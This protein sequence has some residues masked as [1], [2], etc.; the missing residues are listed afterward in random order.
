MYYLQL[1]ILHSPECELRVSEKFRFNSSL[2]ASI[3]YQK[4]VPIAT[5]N[6]IKLNIPRKATNPDK[7]LN[8]SFIVH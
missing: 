5:T 1:H 2:E 8:L 6:K 3:I 4:S 7:M